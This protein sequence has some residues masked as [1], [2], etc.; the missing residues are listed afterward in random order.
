MLVASDALMIKS[1]QETVYPEGGKS[2]LVMVPVPI[3]SDITTRKPVGLERLSVRVSS[4]ST[5][6]SPETG[7]SIV[8][9]VSPTAKLSV[10]LTAV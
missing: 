9:L 3:P 4:G 1:S 7:T 5:I 8:L 2:S 10:P 6:R